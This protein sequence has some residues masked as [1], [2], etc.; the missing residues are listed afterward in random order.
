MSCGPVALTVGE[1]P[2]AMSISWE[3]P[4]SLHF[5]GFIVFFSEYPGRGKM[6]ERRRCRSAFV[7]SSRMATSSSVAV[8]I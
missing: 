3:E 5:S 4:S 8:S 2:P 1:K 7:V 6:I